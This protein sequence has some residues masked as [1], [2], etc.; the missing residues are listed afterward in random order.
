MMLHGW[1]TVCRRIRRVRVSGAGMVMVQR[2]KTPSGVCAA[3]TEAAEAKRRR[4][5]KDRRR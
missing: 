3:C 1:C 2:G 4:Q 5:H